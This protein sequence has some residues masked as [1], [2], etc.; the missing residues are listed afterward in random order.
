MDLD[1]QQLAHSRYYQK[2]ADRIRAKAREYSRNYL[3]KNQDKVKQYQD[4]YRQV[5]DRSDYFR[6]YYRKR[7]EEK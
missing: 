6:E 2:N 1:P 3:E 7:K 4:E 5:V